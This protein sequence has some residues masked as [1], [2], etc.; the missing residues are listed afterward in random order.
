MNVLSNN[1]LQPIQT[2][3][4]AQADYAL[5]DVICYS[6]LAFGLVVAVALPWLLLRKK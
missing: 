2:K 5:K 1:N 4:Q 6:Y 3:E